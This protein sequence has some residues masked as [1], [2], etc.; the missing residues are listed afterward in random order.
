MLV[1]LLNGAAGSGTGQQY[2]PVPE[3]DKVLDW[4]RTYT[5]KDFTFDYIFEVYVSRGSE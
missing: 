5:I 2:C 3:P 4:G 1:Q